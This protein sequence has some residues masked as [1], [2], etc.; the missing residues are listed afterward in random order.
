[1]SKAH[2]ISE[3]HSIILFLDIFAS[4]F[5]HRQVARQIH[6]V[7]GQIL[8]KDTDLAPFA[9]KHLETMR[10]SRRFMIAKLV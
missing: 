7:H 3:Y 8:A 6:I 10:I 2:W 1:M 5:S 9:S 4:P